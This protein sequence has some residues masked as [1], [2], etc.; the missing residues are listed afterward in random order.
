MKN[1]ELKFEDNLIEVI[2]TEKGYEVKL[3][4]DKNVDVYIN[5][6]CIYSEYEEEAYKYIPTTI[7]EF[8]K[9]HVYDIGIDNNS[10]DIKG[11]YAEMTNKIDFAMYFPKNKTQKITARFT[12]T[13][14]LKDILY[15]IEDFY[16]SDEEDEMNKA[17]NEITQA[18]N[19]MT[20]DLKELG[21][22]LEPSH[23]MNEGFWGWQDIKFKAK[24]WNKD[25][26]LKAIDIINK[27]DS[28]F[29]IIVKKHEWGV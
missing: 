2:K 1:Q 26:F 27:Y 15:L 20:N 5:D 14:P 4:L 23:S 16:S 21:F 10:Y 8:V 19:K 12:M 6:D 18:Y 28:E 13:D 29:N 7:R 3:K 11:T 24:D 22:K 25:L 9:E 17:K